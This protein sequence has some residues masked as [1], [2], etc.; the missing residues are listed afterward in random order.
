MGEHLLAQLTKDKII[1]IVRGIPEGTGFQTAEALRAGGI[2]FLEVTMNTDGALSLIYDLREKYGEELRVGAGTVLDLD[3]AKEAIQAGSE[4]LIS[5]NLD[6]EVLAYGLEQGVEV[7][8][9]T[10]TPTEIVRAY[11]LGAS[12]VKVFPIG[13]LGVKY[14]K[15]LRAPLDSIPMVAT[16]GVNLDNI[17]EVL[18]YGAT[19]VGLGGNLVNNN[20]IKNGDFAQ[21]TKLAKAYTDLANEVELCRELKRRMW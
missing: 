17:K 7:W 14:I 16:G 2:S 8:P 21:I 20:F 1:A 9:G 5:P 3:M 10:M 15:D 19:A 4:Y 13:S 6:E 12:A 11:K 18:G